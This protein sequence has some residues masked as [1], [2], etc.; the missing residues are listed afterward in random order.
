MS[1]LVWRPMANTDRGEGAQQHGSVSSLATT[2]TNENIEFR[3]LERLV[4]MK[5]RV[6]APGRGSRRAKVATSDR[7]T[8][9][10][11]MNNMNNSE[12]WHQL[13]QQCKTTQRSPVHITLLTR[14]GGWM[15]S[16]WAPYKE[17]T[18]VT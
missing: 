9:L 17:Y 5:H 13:N 18:A 7:Q 15:P 2:N 1:N 16:L 14:S 10:S 3:L 8:R 4:I 6:T 12:T 11:T